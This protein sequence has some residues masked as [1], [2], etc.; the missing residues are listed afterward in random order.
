MTLRN[1]ETN[2]TILMKFI[3]RKPFNKEKKTPFLVI[4]A[5]HRQPSIYL[6]YPEYFPQ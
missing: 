3:A 4:I 1:T 5:Y 2:I 6:S